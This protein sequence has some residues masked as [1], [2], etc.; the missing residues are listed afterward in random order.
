MFVRL[1]R[2]LRL[3]A[4]PILLL[5]VAILCGGRAGYGGLFHHKDLSTRTRGAWLDPGLPPG[6]AGDFGIG[7]GRQAGAPSRPGCFGGIGSTTN[8]LNGLHH[9]YPWFRGYIPSGPRPECL[10]Q[11][12]ALPWQRD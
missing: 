1:L 11:T 3:K 10:Y 12:G 4:L 9:R 2:S 5:T 6:Q 8:V 7:P